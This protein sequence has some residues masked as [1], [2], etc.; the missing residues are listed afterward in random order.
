[1]K[2]KNRELRVAEVLLIVLFLVALFFTERAT[3]RRW[4]DESMER[5]MAYLTKTLETSLE[6]EKQDLK[7][8]QQV[9]SQEASLAAFYFQNT[10]DDFRTAEEMQRLLP[11][12]NAKGI[13]LID[14][15]GRLLVGSDEREGALGFE[16]P[17][18]ESLLRVSQ[19]QPVSEPVADYSEHDKITVESKESAAQG[20]GGL[21]EELESAGQSGMSRSEDEMQTVEADGSVWEQEADEADETNRQ[22]AYHSFVSARLDED[23]IV[24]LLL[25]ISDGM[26]DESQLKT[27]FVDIVRYNSFGDNG[28]CFLADQEGNV[29]V[30]P[31]AFEKDHPGIMGKKIPK[32]LLK[33][34][35]AGSMLLD[36]IPFYCRSAFY[37]TLGVY[38]ISVTPVMEFLPILIFVSIGILAVVLIVIYLMRL[39]ARLLLV[40]ETEHGANKSE[41]ARLFRKRL[42]TMLLLGMACTIGIHIFSNV[43]YFYTGRFRT[44]GKNAAVIADEVRDFGRKQAKDSQ[45]YRDFMEVNTK[46][47]AA[48]LSANPQMLATEPL[49]KLAKQIGAALILVYGKTGVVQAA[50]MNFAGQTLSDDP[51]SMSYEFRWVLRGE[52][53]LIQDSVDEAFLNRPYRYSG[54][55]LTDEEGNYTGMV[56]IAMDPSVYEKMETAISMQA[57]MGNYI[58]D[59]NSDVLAIDMETGRVSSPNS[60]YDG[61]EAKSLTLDES[62]LK[63]HYTGFFR[64]NGAHMLGCCEDSDLF[65]IL[66]ISVTAG[67]AT[68][69]V[70]AGITTCLPGI[71]TELLFFFLLLI[72]AKQI[73][74]LP[75]HEIRKLVNEQG[76]LK[77][78]ISAAGG[79][80]IRFLNRILFFVS[81]IVTFAF[82]FGGSL[83]P[84]GSLGYYIFVNEWGRGIYIFTVTRCLIYIMVA[85]FMLST[86]T[87]LFNLLGTLLP[88]RQETIIR[89]AMSFLKYIVG[90]GTIIVCAGLLG[91]PTASVLASAGVI[92]VVV[93]FGA[94]TFLA[95]IIAGLFIIIEG[96]YKVG[97][98]ITV[99]DWHGQVVEINIRNTKLRD[100]ITDDDKVINNSMIRTLINFS[101]T[102]SWCATKVGV[103][104]DQN[105]PELEAIFEREKAAMV[106]NIPKA[107]GE[108]VF[109][110]IE[111]FADSCIILKFQVHCKNQDYLPVKRALNREI[112]LM[113][114]R[115]GINV[116]FPQIV[117]SEREKGTFGNGSGV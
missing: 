35:A 14:R 70:L 13:Y 94:Q 95:D 39:Y 80:I 71:V 91:A 75:N 46:A 101:E 96:T 45:M 55:P 38:V 83:F 84:P 18:Y 57:V 112:K 60:G 65:H 67:L 41:A 19:D 103:D 37:D 69:G 73:R 92:S 11:A 61:M 88:A 8:Q 79:S 64:L 33:E 24:V 50:N 72:Y 100:L 40:E 54:A 115:N 98:M 43:L 110:G 36:N 87:N 93:S 104:Y 105:I 82:L 26:Y 52:P 34:G 20:T 68:K 102:P 107:I 78:K 97:D 90:L 81:G 7:E 106:K 3:V 16:D 5:T 1:M 86:L 32:R 30:F 42:M 15:D 44:N 49:S 17:Y 62:I 111:E 113:F 74:T 48:L 31:E 2:K 116:P 22:E 21:A 66:V 89:M 117:V 85:V 76:N 59:D 56:Q 6:N 23:R 53:L 77:G 58:I 4:L 47:T 12:F 99:D 109:L 51:N 25:P 29:F 27:D 114:E 9:L 28:F 63:D 10:S 108:I